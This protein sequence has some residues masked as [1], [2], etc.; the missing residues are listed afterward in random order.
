MLGLYSGYH[1]KAGEE[2]NSSTK[3]DFL[4]PDR[5]KVE[6]S[7]TESLMTACRKA[8]S[9][10]GTRNTGRALLNI[11]FLQG[12]VTTGTGTGHATG[13]LPGIDAETPRG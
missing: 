8:I 9:A 6:D 12:I 2:G 13:A 5:R 11:F 3:P 10:I 7:V 1:Q 4:R